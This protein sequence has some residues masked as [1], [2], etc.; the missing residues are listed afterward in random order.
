[1]VRVP[2]TER[3]CFVLRKALIGSITSSNSFWEHESAVDS[4][5]SGGRKHRSRRS[6]SWGIKSRVSA[7]RRRASLHHHIA[8]SLFNKGPYCIDRGGWEK[9][10]DIKKGCRWQIDCAIVCST[11]FVSAIG[12]LYFGGPH[13]RH[14][15]SRHFGRSCCASDPFLELVVWALLAS[16]QIAWPDSHRLMALLE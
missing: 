15:T 5:P 2:T 10:S 14:A 6:G 11:F 8:M 3:T 16:K 7:K 4:P 1:V 9:G 13:A 12:I